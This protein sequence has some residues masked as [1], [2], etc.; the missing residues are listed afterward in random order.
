MVKLNKKIEFHDQFKDFI[1]IE[2]LSKIFFLILKKK[3]YGI[4]NVSLGQKI[5]VSEILKWLNTNNKN[6]KNFV[7]I[8]KK[9]EKINR[10]SF[11]LK[12]SK[13][14]RVINYKPKKSELKKFC[15]R[16]SKIIH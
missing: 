14:Y 10:Y 12:N 5:Y 13:L 3:L 2:Q 4:Y 6:K 9:R 15:M 11:S 16:L 7:L 1:S 8:K